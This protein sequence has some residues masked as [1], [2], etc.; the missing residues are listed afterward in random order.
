MF[1]ILRVRGLCQKTREGDGCAMRVGR[2]AVRNEGWS[3]RFAL[4]FCLALFCQ[5]FFASCGGSGDNSLDD[6]GLDITA[7]PQDYCLSFKKLELDKDRRL[8]GLLCGVTSE[9][10]YITLSD[11]EVS[12]KLRN[13]R[14]F[15]YKRDDSPVASG[16]IEYS[17]LQQLVEAL[18][19]DMKESLPPADLLS[20]YDSGD[21]S[22]APPAPKIS[23]GE[24]EYDIHRSFKLK[25][26]RNHR[27][28]LIALPIFSAVSVACDTFL[29]FPTSKHVYDCVFYPREGFTSPASSFPGVLEIRDQ[30]FYDNP[31]QVQKRVLVMGR[32]D[33]QNQKIS[34]HFELRREAC[35]TESGPIELSYLP[36]SP[37][38]EDPSAPSVPEGPAPPPPVALS[39]PHCVRLNS[40]SAGA[41]G[42]WDGP[43]PSYSTYRGE[44]YGQIYAQ[45]T[46][47]TAP[48]EEEFLWN[49]NEGKSVW[50]DNGETK[51]IGNSAAVSL[52][53]TGDSIA[54]RFQGIYDRDIAV[55]D[56]DDLLTPSS[57][58]VPSD[59]ETTKEAVL[60]VNTAAITATAPLSQSATFRLESSDEGAS[61]GEATFNFTISSGACSVSP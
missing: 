21:A 27:V 18:A 29:G 30:D 33:K 24:T 23:K 50:L 51:V 15:F 43:F 9:D 3:R 37:A 32:K 48:P 41:T 58:A 10:E 53:S 12:E 20:L 40:L 59:Y 13:C 31:H 26:K 55:S 8:Y 42:A 17:L 7:T 19:P 49:K 4:L 25:D 5:I 47:D 39:N 11:T 45:G 46:A 22:S 14:P 56:A 44:I 35:A 60:N 2:T 38:D 16:A 52:G 61:G 34:F 54:L 36:K 1:Y 6:L 28:L 57:F